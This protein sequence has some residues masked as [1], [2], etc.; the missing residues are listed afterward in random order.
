VQL[1]GDE[2]Q[3]VVIKFAPRNPGV[4]GFIV[5]QQ[6]ST[7]DVDT[8]QADIWFPDSVDVLEGSGLSKI[9]EARWTRLKLAMSA[10][11][12]EDSNVFLLRF[13]VDGVEGLAGLRVFRPEKPT[14]AKYVIK[15]AIMKDARDTTMLYK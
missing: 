13:E 11:S 5:R 14:E 4:L 12:P 3:L 2:S 10:K 1:P 9:L 8:V 6:L 15:M 7:G